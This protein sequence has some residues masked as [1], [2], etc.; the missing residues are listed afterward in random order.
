MLKHGEET[1]NFFKDFDTN[2]RF[3]ILARIISISMNEEIIQKTKQLQ[4]FFKNDPSELV[5]FG[6]RMKKI[7]LQW[8]FEAIEQNMENLYQMWKSDCIVSKTKNEK[9]DIKNLGKSF[10]KEF[11]HG[12]YLTIL[13]FLISLTARDFSFFLRIGISKKNNEFTV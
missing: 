8:D 1:L 5:D 9:D 10:S 12:D 11:V 13:R 7:G 4:D 2:M 6:K 3:T